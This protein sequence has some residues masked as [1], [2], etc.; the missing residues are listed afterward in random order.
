[1]LDAVKNNGAYPFGM[2]KVAGEGRQARDPPP[3]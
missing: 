2:D 3:A 1:M